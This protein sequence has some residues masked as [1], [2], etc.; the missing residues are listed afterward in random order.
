MLKRFFDFFISFF[1]LIVFFPFGII[2]SLLI[3][4]ESKGGVFYFQKRVGKNQ[5]EFILW[6]FRTMKTNA[7]KEG[8]L[9]IGMR[10]KRITR[11]GYFLRKYKIDEF[12]QFINVLKGDMSIVGPRP[13][14][15]EYVDLYSNDQKKI[16][17]VKPGIT[18][19]A[20]LHYFDE[21][22]IL[23]ESEIPKKTYIY[24]IM[25]KKIE[26]NIKYIHEISVLT[27]LKII[28]LTAKKILYRNKS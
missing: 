24:E 28:Y 9:T 20:S 18:D 21:N 22:K 13:E 25:P 14:V 17:H 23:G 16:L 19:Y 15:K 2:I 7:D 4:I 11:I 3:L 1:I 6:K 5:I 10:D 26:L 8:Q 12:P 27:D